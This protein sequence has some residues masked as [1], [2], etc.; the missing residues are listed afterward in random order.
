MA[1]AAMAFVTADR[2]NI[3]A[4]ASTRWPPGA[5]QLVDALVRDNKREI[6]QARSVVSSAGRPAWRAAML[7]AIETTGRTV[8]LLRRVLDVP[9]FIGS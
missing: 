5:Q 3:N 1:S 8:R 7:G 6:S 2:K 9:D 4:L